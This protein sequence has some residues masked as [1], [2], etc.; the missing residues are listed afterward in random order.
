MSQSSTKDLYDWAS[1]QIDK[2][3]TPTTRDKLLLLGGQYILA[4]FALGYG[5]GVKLFNRFMLEKLKSSPKSAFVVR[6]GI[7]IGI[8]ALGVLAAEGL[9]VANIEALRKAS[10]EQN[11]PSSPVP[12]DSK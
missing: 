11:L 8:G 10:L 6:L 12:Q 7:P 9:F 5:V 3:S 4:P 2:P 1:G